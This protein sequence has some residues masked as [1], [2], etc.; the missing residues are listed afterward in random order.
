MTGSD[1]YVFIIILLL[2]V[3]LLVKGLR[4]WLT[5]EDEDDQPNRSEIEVDDEIP[6]TEAVRLLESSGYEVMTVKRKI[7]LKFIVNDEEEYQS[8]LFVD[9]FVRDHEEKLYAVKIAKS[10]QPLEM[11][12]SQLRDKMMVYPL[13][14]LEIE[15]VLYV[16]PLT[17]TIKKIYFEVE[18]D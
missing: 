16:D 6:V 12:G 13:L 17:Q 1:R 9:H 11:T 10:R 5:K 2:V 3:Y 14:F 18:G 8:R 15:G 4:K 7:N